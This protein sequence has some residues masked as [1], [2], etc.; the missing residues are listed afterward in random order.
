MCE[1]ED[2]Y[3][4]MF[5]D[6]DEDLKSITKLIETLTKG[7]IEN[8]RGRIGTKIAEFDI[9]KN[10]DFNTSKEFRSNDP[11]DAFLF[12]RYYIDIEPKEG[13]EPSFVSMISQLLKNLRTK[14]ID[15]VVA[16][17]FEDKLPPR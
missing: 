10:D 7:K 8:E 9:R 6:F 16:C 13:V 17:D 1:I 11:A 14:G 12:W 5:V 4:K 2:L 3:C 15:T